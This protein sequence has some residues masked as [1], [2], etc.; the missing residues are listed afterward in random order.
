VPETGPRG[1]KPMKQEAT[2]LQRIHCAV[3]L[4]RPRLAASTQVARI[5]LM[6][7]VSL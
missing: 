7:L 2:D 4:P 6:I 1:D 5:A 3:E